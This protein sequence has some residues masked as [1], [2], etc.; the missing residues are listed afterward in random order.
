MGISSIA[1]GFDS[2]GEFIVIIV[3]VVVVA[4]YPSVRPSLT[5]RHGVET[6]EHMVKLLPS[7]SH[8]IPVFLHQ[9]LWQYSDGDPIMGALNA[10]EV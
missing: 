4:R 9:T 2:L 10:G 5:R 1:L 3:V 6:A 8:V 7:S